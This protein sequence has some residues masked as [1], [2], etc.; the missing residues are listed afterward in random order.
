MIVSRWK[1][2]GLYKADAQKVA[3]EILTLGDSVEP[4]A[5]VEKAKDESTELHKCFE[6]RDD[7]AAEK[8]RLH[9]AGNLIRFICIASETEQQPI[10]IR[11]FLKT[12]AAQPYKSLNVIMQS[13][14]D[15]AAMLDR[16]RRELAA[17]K[18]KYQALTELKP[19]FDAISS[20][21]SS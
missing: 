10:P 12:E 1:V 7:V 21:E 8:Y 15:Y 13:A 16:A 5:V 6:W 14:D 11:A 20:L 17:F 19:V 3:D 4:S 9:Q 2:Q 18:N